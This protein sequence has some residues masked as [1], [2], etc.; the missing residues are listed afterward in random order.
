MSVVLARVDSN[1]LLPLQSVTLSLVCR[2]GQACSKCM[3][4]QNLEAIRGYH[5]YKKGY[6]NITPEFR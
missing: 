1:D 2:T 6:L 4:T 5:S 3:V